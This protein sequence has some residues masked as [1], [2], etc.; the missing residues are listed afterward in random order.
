MSL[1]HPLR[2]SLLKLKYF[3]WVLK[4]LL[5]KEKAP[6]EGRR[7]EADRCKNG[8]HNTAKIL[9]D[10][11]NLCLSCCTRGPFVS[12]RFSLLVVRATGKTQ[13]WAKYMLPALATTWSSFSKTGLCIF[14]MSICVCL[15]AD[16][17]IRGQRRLPDVGA[18]RTQILCKSRMYSYPLSHRSCPIQN[19]FDNLF[20]SPLENI[21]S[22]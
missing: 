21:N 13:Y 19:L 3:L 11:N 12:E 6:A 20:Y 17:V 5:W 16:S 7:Q 1:P 2:L 10:L 15:W 9:K 18:E 4:Y 14:N 22:Y 8:S